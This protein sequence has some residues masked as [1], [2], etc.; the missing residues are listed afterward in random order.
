M[1]VTSFRVETRGT[2]DHVTVWIDGAN[3][4]TLIVGA[5]DGPELVAL[6]GLQAH[7]DED[8]ATFA[9]ECRRDQLAHERMFGGPVPRDSNGRI[10]EDE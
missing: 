6:L 1:K 8:H 2:H 4:G 7:A 10:L 5:C 9:D 3:V